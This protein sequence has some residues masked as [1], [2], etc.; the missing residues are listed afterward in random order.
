MSDTLERRRHQLEAFKFYP[1]AAERARREG[2]PDEAWR[3]WRWQRA[4]LARL[5]ALEGGTPDVAAAYEAVLR[6]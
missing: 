2:W 6:R 4:S 1:S 3:N 5:L